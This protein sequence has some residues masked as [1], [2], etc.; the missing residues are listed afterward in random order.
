MNRVNWDLRYPAPTIAQRPPEPEEEIFGDPPSGPLVMPG[1]YT[2]QLARRVGGAIAPL[3]APQTFTVY[4]EGQATMDGADRAA[5]VEFQQKVARLQRAVN[6]ATETVNQLRARI[7]LI[8]RAL[9]ETPAAEYKL[10]E[11]ATAIDRKAAEIQRALR[12][13]AAARGRNEFTPP[14][15]ADRVG[16]IVGEQRMS[17]ARPTETQREQYAAAAK[18]FEQALGQLRTLVEGDLARLEKA[19]EAAG[20][21]WT[22]GRI[23]EWK[24]N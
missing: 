22:P 14:S 19:M 18:D 3:S 5:L 24:D 15:I 4:V 13:D 10:T 9:Q 1:K 7:A 12:G 21:P 16:G 2:V 6:G 8:K 11:D 23:P 20:A 17:T